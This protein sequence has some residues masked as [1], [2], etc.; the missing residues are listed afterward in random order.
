MMLGSL[1]NLLI[2]VTLLWVMLFIMIV[3]LV[4]GVSSNIGMGSSKL[5][6]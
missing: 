6:M 5:Y 2:V 4:Y 1:D 3:M